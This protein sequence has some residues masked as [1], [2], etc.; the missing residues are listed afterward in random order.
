MKR[1]INFWI[2]AAIVIVIVLAVIV[3]SAI[4]ITV[5]LIDKMI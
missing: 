1:Q 4:S 5:L 3:C 2:K